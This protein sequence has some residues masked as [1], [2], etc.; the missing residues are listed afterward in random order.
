MESASLQVTVDPTVWV[1]YLELRYENILK[2]IANIETAIQAI[3]KI[4]TTWDCHSKH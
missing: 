4:Y 3:K 2:E 1:K